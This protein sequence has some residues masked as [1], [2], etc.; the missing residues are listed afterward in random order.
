MAFAVPYL[1]DAL[2]ILGVFILTVGVYGMIRLPDTYLKL[3][4]GSKAV[5]LGLL[6]LLLAAALTEDP[7][8][9]YRAALIAAALL[10]TTPI[11]AHAI[12]KAAY[13]RGEKMEAPR[14]R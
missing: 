12:A 6:P 5:L 7:A 1:A 4:P 10:L 11:S 9:V 14:D 8:I 3:H 2:V 13:Q